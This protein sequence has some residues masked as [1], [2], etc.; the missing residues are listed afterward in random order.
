M[1]SL[2]MLMRGRVKNGRKL[3]THII[4]ELELETNYVITNKLNKKQILTPYISYKSVIR[5]FG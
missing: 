3:R 5:G 1:Q 4:D 2:N